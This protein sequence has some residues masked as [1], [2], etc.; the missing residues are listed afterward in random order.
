[1]GNE[2]ITLGWNGTRA[3]AKGV[4][5]YAILAVLAII[6]ATLYSGFRIEQAMTMMQT[7]VTFEHREI[8][9]AMNRTSCIITM[10]QEDRTKFRDRYQS[11]DFKRWCPWITE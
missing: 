10:A 6:G 3:T 11:G 1:V 7:R 5:V 4:A 2:E 9:I 8:S